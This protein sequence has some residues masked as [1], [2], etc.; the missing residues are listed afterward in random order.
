MGLSTKSDLTLLIQEGEG[1]T[2]EFKEKFTVKIAQD[3]CAFA[4]SRGGCLLLGVADNGRLVGEHLT[5]QM[6]AEIF[7]LGRNCDPEIEI[8][9]KQLD[10]VVVVAVAEGGEK[11]YSCAGV[12]YKRFDAVTQK[13]TRNETKAAFVAN[14]G[15][16]FDSRANADASPSDISLKKVKDFYKTAGIKYPVN[17]KRLPDILKS[18]NL[19]KGDKINHAGVLFFAAK[20]DQ[21]FLHSQVMLLAFKDLKGVHIFDRK[22]VRGDLVTQFNEAEFFLKRHL[23]LQAII[24]TTRRKNEYEIPLTAWREA[25]ANAII[26][27]DYQYSGTSIQVR[28][29]PDRI[30]IIS[31]G[32]LPEGVTAKNI[33]GKSARRNEIIADMFARM[34]VVEKAGTGILRIREAMKDA[35][36]KPPKFE[37]MG[38]FLK[39]VLF[40]PKG[41]RDVEKDVGSDVEKDVGT[42]SDNQRAIYEQIKLKPIV[43]ARELAEKVG[44]TLRNVQKNIDSL[45]ARGLINRVGPDK[46]GHWVIR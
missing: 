44:I 6:K 26:H 7:S 28:V 9:V 8:K 12:Y 13:L 19:M 3:I 2:V 38:N 23:S 29:F 18:L 46:G 34:D 1:L 42:L 43:T 41:V 16:H 30:E 10:D 31:P 32:G 40:R 22:E 4:N 35:G 14:V 45:K 27:R 20:I 5:G 39:I 21:F 36:L 33:G 24:E 15:S 11:P 37:D 17:Q 25:I